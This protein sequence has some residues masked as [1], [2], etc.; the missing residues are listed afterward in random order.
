MY[1]RQPLT[2]T[3]SGRAHTYTWCPR[4]GYVGCNIVAGSSTTSTTSSP[5]PPSWR[6]LRAAFRISLWQAR[7]TSRKAGAPILRIGIHKPFPTRRSK[8]YRV[9]VGICRMSNVFFSLLAEKMQRTDV[10]R[11]RSAAKVHQTMMQIAI[12]MMLDL[13]MD[14]STS[15]DPD[16]KWRLCRRLGAGFIQEPSLTSSGSWYSLLTTSVSLPVHPSM[17]QRWRPHSRQGPSNQQ[18]SPRVLTSTPSW[19]SHRWCHLAKLAELSSSHPMEMSHSMMVANLSYLTI[20]S[21]LV[22]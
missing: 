4:S 11:S 12:R 17:A 13:L 22:S 15:P 2:S 19:T 8:K 6:G 1:K 14:S 9:T 7:G 16:S 21:F 3:T 18:P 5:P 10:V 20:Q